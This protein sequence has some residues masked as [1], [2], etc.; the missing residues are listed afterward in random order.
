MPQTDI[1]PVI[2]LVSFA[3][4]IRFDGV[5]CLLKPLFLRPY[6]A[7]NGSAGTVAALGLV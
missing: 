3:L 4:H 2:R 7:N 1:L 6:I 5:G